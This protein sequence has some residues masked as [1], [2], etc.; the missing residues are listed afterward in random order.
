VLDVLW[1]RP[2]FSE[3][4]SQIF[5]YV[6]KRKIEGLLCATTITTIFYLTAKV[7]DK[8]VALRE[9]KKLL[10]LFDVAPVN[11][12][13]LVS[14]T[15]LMFNDF[16]DAVLHEAAKKSAAKGIV[17]RNVRDYKCYVAFP[18]SRLDR[19]RCIVPFLNF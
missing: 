16:E 14:A 19:S 5:S 10:S 12:E 6:E 15:D 8:K 11:H 3:V 9:I 4:A 1:D 13:V 17:T 2:P 7:A 18:I